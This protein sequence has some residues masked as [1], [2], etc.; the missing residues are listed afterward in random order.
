MSIRSL[1]SLNV[2]SVCLSTKKSK[3]LETCC[4]FELV[5]RCVD[6]NFVSF[7]KKL[8]FLQILNYKYKKHKNIIFTMKI[9]QYKSFYFLNVTNCKQRDKPIISAF[10]KNKICGAE[11]NFSSFIKPESKTTLVY[12]IL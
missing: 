10:R 11:T 12:M 7:F 8:N 9:E 1:S 5:Q 2:A 4:I 3:W 6:G